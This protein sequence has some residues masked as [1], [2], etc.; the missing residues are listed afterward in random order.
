MF[1]TQHQYSVT[2]LAFC[3]AHKHAGEKTPYHGSE[4]VGVSRQ[5]AAKAEH[6]VQLYSR[7]EGL[8]TGG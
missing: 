5:Q 4:M 6:T 2:Y 3:I 8:L 1:S 7:M